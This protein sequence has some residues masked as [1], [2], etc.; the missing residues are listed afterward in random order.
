[1]NWNLRQQDHARSLLDKLQDW[2]SDRAEKYRKMSTNSW[3]NRVL[4]VK[5]IELI[6]LALSSAC[7]NLE[8]RGFISMFLP[9][10]TTFLT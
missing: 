3:N 6:C 4:P 5:L 2:D 10:N 8:S 7:T 1:M 9:A